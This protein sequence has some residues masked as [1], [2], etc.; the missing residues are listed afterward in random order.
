LSTP[1][2]IC[3]D[4][5]ILMLPLQFILLL[6]LVSL[7]RQLAEA[8][9]DA[10]GTPPALHLLPAPLAYGMLVVMQVGVVLLI[11][12]QTRRAIRLLHEP[13]SA[14]GPITL[15]TDRLFAQCRVGASLLTGAVLFTTPL[16][17][18]VL[19]WFDRTA[20]VKYLMVPELLFMLPALLAWLAIWTAG[21]YVEEALRQRSLPYQLA[22]AIPVHEMPS[23]GS[24]LVTQGRHNFYPVVFLFFQGFTT[25]AADITRHF[26]HSDA[27]ANTAEVVITLISFVL[28]LALLPFF[29]TRFW[30]TTPLLGALRQRLEEVAAR[31]SL[32][33]RDIRLWR[34]HHLILNAAIVGWWRR[35]RY[36]LI[37]DTLVETLSD[38]QLEAVFAHEVGHGIH[39][40]LHWMMGAILS[41]VALATGLTG[42]AM[43]FLPPSAQ[44]GD[45]GDIISLLLSSGLFCAMGA[46]AIATISPRFEH[47][48]D[49]FACRHMALRLREGPEAT[50]APEATEPLPAALAGALA[51]APTPAEQVTVT[52]YRAGAYPHNP[53]ATAPPPPSVD[54][55]P[56][57]LAEL[58]GAEIFISSLDLLVEA[59]HRDR[60]RRGL[61]HPSAANRMALL[62]RL[63]LDP[64]AEIGFN[65]TLR[66]VRWFI[67]LLAAV[68]V[69]TIG[70]ALLL[71]DTPPMTPNDHGAAVAV[72][73]DAP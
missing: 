34:T 61:F 47:Q 8:A 69:A 44:T 62:R 19:H 37:T 17:Q 72:P 63:A 41:V 25:A 14:A 50:A 58:A 31:H 73:S 2:V 24:Y 42:M 68:G 38:R 5:L 12:R 45:L 29:L 54:P 27:Q 7:P 3:P 11:L 35:G 71:E 16:A 4:I 60:N 28:L 67:V 23:L 13:S 55:L 39:R 49:W 22:Q 57:S 46:G 9:Q 53:G 43:A 30:S 1:P 20:I 56:A 21:Y 40:H 6:I 70:T 26:T 51:V 64:A 33:F 48:A 15:K 59:S 65:R 66:R 36:F 32:R 10:R 52:D 18:V